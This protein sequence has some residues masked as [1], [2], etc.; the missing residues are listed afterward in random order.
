MVSSILTRC[1][2]AGAG[3]WSATGLEYRRSP[4]GWGF[5]SSARGHQFAKHVDVDPS[6]NFFRI[7]LTYYLT[8]SAECLYIWNA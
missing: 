2:T 4:S 8:Y 7:S 1:S 6:A 5:D 3:G